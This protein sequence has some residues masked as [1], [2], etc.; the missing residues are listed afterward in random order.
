MKPTFGILFVCRSERCVLPCLSAAVVFVA[1]L[2]PARSC[3]GEPNKLCKVKT[4]R[5]LT[6]HDIAG[7]PDRKRHQL[8][9][10]RP[11]GQTGRPVLFFVHGGAWMISGKDDVFGIYGY[12]AI[13][14]CFAQRGLVVASPNYRLSPGV[15]HPEHIKD[16][17]RAFAWTRQNIAKYGG[18]PKRIFVAGHS[19]GGHLVSLLTTDA[20][21][22]KAEGRSPK[23]IR[24]AIGI[25][26]VY[27]VEDF[28]FKLGFSAPC[29]CLTFRAQ[30]R[31]F[32]SVFGSDPKVIEQ[33][34]PMAHV[35]PGLPPFLLL[36]AGFDYCPL[37][38]AT[39]DFAAAL[40]KND[41][42]VEVRV[43]PWSTHETLVFDILHQRAE[44]KMI[45]AVVTFIERRSADED[46]FR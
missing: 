19:A 31:P 33:A 28:D 6:Y 14:R 23:D 7:D 15:K 41:C 17:A 25:S 40:K 39:K 30:V 34:S 43:I 13:A 9:V 45:D 24:G 12:G 2:V 44:P 10:Y 4:F 36:S 1:L 29:K 16:V 37:R 38:R 42:A 20:T 11:K 46:P 18:D 21:Y 8:D 35:R 26:G 5:N 3:A 22:L 27:R 32:A